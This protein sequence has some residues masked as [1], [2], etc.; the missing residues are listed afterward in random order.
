MMSGVERKVFSIYQNPREGEVYIDFNDH[1]ATSSYEV[2]NTEGLILAEK[3]NPGIRNTISLKNYKKGV[4]TVKV[5][6]KN[7]I[8]V[9]NFLKL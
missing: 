5:K 3:N 4:Y 9:K 1:I 8:L 2:L 7:K 6:S